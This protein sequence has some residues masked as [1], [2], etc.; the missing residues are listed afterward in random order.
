MALYL[1]GMYLPMYRG[2]CCLLLMPL[3]MDLPILR[4][5]MTNGGNRSGVWLPAAYLSPGSRM[6]DLDQLAIPQS[7]SPFY[8]FASMLGA[9]SA[10]RTLL[11]PNLPACMETP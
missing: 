10:R 8:L 6:P 11:V 5:I 1:P 2:L 3:F 7:K 9:V 4:P